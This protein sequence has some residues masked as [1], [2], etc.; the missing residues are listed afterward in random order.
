[1]RLA[2][3]DT[4]IINQCQ[5]NLLTGCELRALLKKKN[6][7]PILGPHTTFELSKDYLNGEDRVKKFFKILLELDPEYTCKRSFMY[8][9]EYRKIKKI[10][11]A[12]DFLAPPEFKEKIRRRVLN[13]ANGSFSSENFIRAR[14]DSYDTM[15]KGWDKTK[16]VTIPG[17]RGATFF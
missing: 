11:A 6:L 14:Q 4:S 16:M 13:Y 5:K 9:M 17:I 7:I 3:L 12:E 1:M 2:F 8:E 10:I 15:R